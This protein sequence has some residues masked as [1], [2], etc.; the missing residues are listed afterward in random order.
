[1][2]EQY[3]LAIDFRTARNVSVPLI[4]VNHWTQPPP[5]EPL[6]GHWSMSQA[7]PKLIPTTNSAS[8]LSQY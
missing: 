1:M 7:P 5:C 2:S 6:P 3:P 4:A 8:M